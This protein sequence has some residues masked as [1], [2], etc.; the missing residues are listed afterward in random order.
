MGVFIRVSK[1]CC[2]LCFVMTCTIISFCF[3]KRDKWTSLDSKPIASEVIFSKPSSLK[4]YET[5]A[6]M[7]AQSPSLLTNWLAI[8]SPRAGT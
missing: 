3:R 1:H 2:F 4:V 8:D 5:A 7:H 6:P